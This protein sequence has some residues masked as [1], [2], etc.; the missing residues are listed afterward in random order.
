MHRA[1]S[2]G[3]DR[4]FF[5]LGALGSFVREGGLLV[6]SVSWGEI[7]CIRF[8][9]VGVLVLFVSLV[10]C[11]GSLSSLSAASSG[12]VVGLSSIFCLHVFTNSP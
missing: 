2:E 7:V 12:V 4:G 6:A 5:T 11:C 10:C 3:K 8:F 9:C 1:P